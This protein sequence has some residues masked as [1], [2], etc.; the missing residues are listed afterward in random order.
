MAI[1]D[2]ESETKGGGQ[3]SVEYDS[4]AANTEP[5]NVATVVDREDITINAVCPSFVL[6]P[7]SAAWTEIAPSNLWCQMNDVVAAFERC[8][9]EDLNGALLE[10]T[11]TGIFD[12]SGH[13][14][15]RTAEWV[16]GSL[17]YR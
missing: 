15:E 14:P 7:M 10:I 13:R 12:R 16:N 4:A 9:D 1:Y 6:T 17:A 8:L 11:H 2:H 3:M 5:G